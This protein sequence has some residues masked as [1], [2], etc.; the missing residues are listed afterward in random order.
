MQRFRSA[1]G[2]RKWARGEGDGGMVL[3]GEEAMDEGTIGLPDLDGFEAAD[4][5]GGREGDGLQEVTACADTADAGQVRS[6]GAAEVAGLMTEGAG[7]CGALEDNFAPL[8]ITRR[9]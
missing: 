5:A 1:E 2:W 6:E 7:G 4:E 3:P 9:E 8:G